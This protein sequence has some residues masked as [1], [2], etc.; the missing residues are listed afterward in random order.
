MEKTK[1]IFR[2][3]GGS[4]DIKP[5]TKL[6]EKMEEVAEM[7]SGSSSIVELLQKQVNHEFENE[8]L[9]L[10]MALWCEENGY[11]ETA[12]FF[13]THAVEEERKHGMD[14]INHMLKRKI[15]VLTPAPA[16]SKREYNDMKE[17]LSDAV[18]REIMTTKM[19]AKILHESCMAQDLAYTIAKKYMDEQLE[20]EQLFNSLENLYDMCNGSRIDFEM[21]V[22][23]LKG[24]GKY[25]IGDL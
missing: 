13:S 23:A 7:E 22:S 1:P 2:K 6:V 16:P 20:E 4:M 12:Q 17:V 24:S 19:I 5:E 18:K 14:F 25:K 3:A 9:Y 15:K 10:S 11:P 8:R 21:E